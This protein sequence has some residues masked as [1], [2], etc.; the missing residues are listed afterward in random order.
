MAMILENVYNER[1]VLNNGAIINDIKVITYPFGF[2]IGMY[3]PFSL[4]PKS[5]FSSFILWDGAV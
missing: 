2:I 4:S 5:N 1:S 3:F